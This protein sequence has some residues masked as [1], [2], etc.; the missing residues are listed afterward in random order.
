MWGIIIEYVIERGTELHLERTQANRP[1]PTLQGH[2]RCSHSV[3]RSWITDQREPNRHVLR[4]RLR[5]WTLPPQR[6]TTQLSQEVIA[7]LPSRRT[8]E[9]VRIQIYH[10]HGRQRQADRFAENDEGIH[11]R[12]S[13]KAKEDDQP[14]HE[15]ERIPGLLLVSQQVLFRLPLRSLVPI[16]VR[17]YLTANPFRTSRWHS[18]LPR[19]Y[20]LHSKQ[21]V[22]EL[23]PKQP[24][25]DAE[26]RQIFLHQAV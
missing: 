16:N 20:D 21:E 5:Q 4:S 11:F 14:V 15:N 19:K 8:P 7:N 26:L 10:S 24:I 6:Q 25:Q 3:L 9:R 17:E 18:V 12:T 2:S 23:V 22:L 1:R 13:R